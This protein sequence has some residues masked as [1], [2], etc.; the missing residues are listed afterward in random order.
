VNSTDW[1]NSFGKTSSPSNIDP[2]KNTIVPLGA[3]KEN[4]KQKLLIE[5]GQHFMIY[6]KSKYS[7]LLSCRKIMSHTASVI[8]SLRESHLDSDF[9]PQ[10]FQESTFQV[11]TLCY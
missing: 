6:D 10:T 1:A 11:L 4:Q 3:P 2:L 9:M 5:L 8:M 7:L